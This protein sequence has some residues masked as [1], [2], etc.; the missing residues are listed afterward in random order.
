MAK[1]SLID[2]FVDYANDAIEAD[3][4]YLW[5]GA[6]S[7]I[8]AV[9]GRG[10]FT[11]L[12]PGNDP[13]D[14]LYLT[15]FIIF[16]GE[17][18]VAKS[19]PYSEVRSMAERLGVVISPESI[20]SER[21]ITW[22]ANRPNGVF[23]A[24]PEELSSFLNAQAPIAFKTF[25]CKAYD[26]I[27]QYSR[28]TQRR[29]EEVVNDPCVTLLSTCPQGYLSE[30]FKSADWQQGLPSRI[31][32]V[33]GTVPDPHYR[34]GR[35]KAAEE[36][37]IADLRDLKEIA[38]RGYQVTWSPE[39]EG[40]RTRWRLDQMHVPAVHQHVS[41]Y[42]NRRWV[43]AAKLA[44]IIAVSNGSGEISLAHWDL[45][46]SKLLDIEANFPLVLGETGLNP[47]F[48]TRQR[49]VRFVNLVGRPVTEAEL[50]NRIASDVAPSHV[51][52]FVEELIRSRAICLGT[53]DGTIRTFIANPTKSSAVTFLKQ[54]PT[55]NTN[56]TAEAS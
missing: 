51:E 53:Q 56:K 25:L 48:P 10:V 3:P 24:M 38:R 50:L 36:D 37:I 1:P 7:L 23:A 27:R 8:S 39:A 6:V 33:W 45:A 22:A 46:V 19:F 47:Y 49:I 4:A 30:C 21:L 11:M 26:G 34:P 40:A 41:G 14:R 5:W 35:D 32:W 54:K 17:P 29:G 44:A 55:T 42:W 31:F 13:R 16:V 43:H 2:R 20:T 9:C 52:A 28:S 12:R 18:G 15:T